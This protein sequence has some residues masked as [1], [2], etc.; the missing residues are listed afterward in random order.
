VSD[1]T[2]PKAKFIELMRAGESVGA[3]CRQLGISR[4][5]IANWRNDDPEFRALVEQ[6]VL[7]T[8]A[9][10]RER[11][12]ALGKSR[13]RPT[14]LVRERT[15]Y[16]NKKIAKYVEPFLYQLARGM[17]PTKAA[18]SVGVAIGTVYRWKADDVQFAERWAEAMQE[19]N[20]RLEDEAHR[21][22][23]EGYNPRP[24]FD[25]AGNVVCEIRDYS[26]MLLLAKLR[27]RLPE[28][29]NKPDV[30]LNAKVEVR[31]T[32]E[33]AAERLQQFG[34]PVPLLTTE[35]EDVDDR[36]PNDGSGQGHKQ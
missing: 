15:P 14:Q 26:D 35:F 17:S 20:D 32:R 1:P 28:I 21:R 22:A 18:E 13:R 2:E 9:I 34:L 23:V 12:V 6:A 5:A 7:D 30:S 10:R 4:R 11:H 27:G 8:A 29:Y 3:A 36:D 16:G 31:L 19:A 25:K 33:Q 24:V